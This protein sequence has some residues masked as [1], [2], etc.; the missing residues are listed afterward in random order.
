MGMQDSALLILL[1]CI[2]FFCFLI[3]F[4]CGWILGFRTM[5]DVLDD[6]L[7]M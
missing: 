7:M 2:V 5:T 3:Y 1:Q 6:L 4:F